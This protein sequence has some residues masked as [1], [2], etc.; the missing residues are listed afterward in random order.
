MLFRDSRLRLPINGA[1]R[2]K[3]P[4][5]LRLKCSTLSVSVSGVISAA[6]NSWSPRLVSP[7]ISLVNPLS[8]MTIQQ[9]SMQRWI[10][11]G[12]Y[13]T[14]KRNFAMLGIHPTD[15]HTYFVDELLASLHIKHLVSMFI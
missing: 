15:G 6:S 2:L 13:F 5:T 8:T 4:W 9:I 10:K 14:W 7:A 12:G 1:G 3:E 11:T